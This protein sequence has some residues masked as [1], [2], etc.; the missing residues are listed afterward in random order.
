[1]FTRKRDETI[2]EIIKTIETPEEPQDFK[3]GKPEKIWNYEQKLKEI[4]DILQQRKT[5]RHEKELLTNNNNKVES[6]YD[7]LSLSPPMD[8]EVSIGVS[9]ELTQF[10]IKCL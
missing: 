6:I 2:H 1:M 3:T 5:E 7:E 8:D 9:Q 10:V 4:D